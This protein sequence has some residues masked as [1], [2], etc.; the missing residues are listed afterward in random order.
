MHNHERLDIWHLS[1]ALSVTVCSAIARARIR[2][3]RFLANQ[4][5]RSITSVPSNIAEGSGQPTDPKF[6]HYVGIAIG[7]ITESMSHLKQMEELRLMPNEDLAG[8]RAELRRIRR[9]SESFQ[10]TLLKEPG[11][12][13]L[14]PR[15]ESRSQVP[16]PPSRS[17]TKVP[18][19]E[20]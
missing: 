20:S 5:E 3:H 7:S 2:R 10:R 16:G 14:S 11:G 1:L 15:P 19:P 8:W 4:L 6:A 13:H 9:M 17:Y 12:D 18:R